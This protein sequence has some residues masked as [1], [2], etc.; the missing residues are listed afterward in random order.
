[1]PDRQARVIGGFSAGAYGAINI[2]LHH[3]GVFGSVQ[4][5]SGYYTQTRSGVFAHATRPELAYNSPIDYVASA[6]PDARASI[7]LRAFMFVGRD[8]TASP[9]TA[10]MARALEAA[11][12]SVT[13]ALYPGGHDWQLWHAP[14]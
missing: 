5:W 9:Q 14:P 7:P 1:M 4:S 12:A 11:G 13:Y 8:D 10:P 6:A 2:A 3:L